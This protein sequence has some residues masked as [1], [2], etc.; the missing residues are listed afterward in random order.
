MFKIHLIKKKQKL[1]PI[2]TST[3]TEILSEQLNS[4]TSLLN[5]P[6]LENPDFKGKNLNS[7]YVYP[8]AKN[9]FY[10]Q[11]FSWKYC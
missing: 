8:S 3:G 9:E 4:Y 7:A 11:P 2:T 5:N 1:T 10:V 6:N